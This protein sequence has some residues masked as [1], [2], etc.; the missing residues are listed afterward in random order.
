[1][2]LLATGFWSVLFGLYAFVL[3]FVLLAA[4]VALALWDLARRE[5][6]SRPSTI[7]WVASARWS[8]ASSDA[9]RGTPRRAVTFPERFRGTLRPV[10]DKAHVPP[11]PPARD[12]PAASRAALPILGIIVFTSAATISASAVL[13][14]A[15][16]F[17]T[18]M[19]MLPFPV[20]GAVVA[21]RRPGNPIGWISSRSVA[22]RRWTGPWDCTPTRACAS[23]RRS[24]ARPSR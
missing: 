2:P 1:M 14:D 22:C 4:W 23:R 5:D 11:R 12:A 19:L 17:G 21:S 10:I 20:V 15:S 13:G 8:E 9:A 3:P 18:A 6:L 7:A 16:G 24:P